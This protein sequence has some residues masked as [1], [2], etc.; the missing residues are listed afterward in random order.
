M[1]GQGSEMNLLNTEHGL[2]L[3]RGHANA[4]VAALA[5]TRA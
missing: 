4:L 3:G 5:E 1:P 2:G